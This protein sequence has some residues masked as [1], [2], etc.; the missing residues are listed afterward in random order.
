MDE[1]AWLA[2]RC[3]AHRTDLQAVAFRLFGSTTGADDAYGVREPGS[4]SLT[5]P[6]R[7]G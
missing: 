2:Q 6:A 1:D 5:G 7:V 4:P 3:A